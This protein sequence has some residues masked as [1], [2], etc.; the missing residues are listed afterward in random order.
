MLDDAEIRCGD[1]RRHSGFRWRVVN[2]WR[3]FENN[4][5]SRCWNTDGQSKLL[6]GWIQ[7]GKPPGVTTSKAAFHDGCQYGQDAP[8]SMLKERDTRTP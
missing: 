2:N 7:L 4:I 3:V 1:K 6:V 8:S 5:A